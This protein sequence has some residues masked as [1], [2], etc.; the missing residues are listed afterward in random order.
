MQELSL[1]LLSLLLCV[2]QLISSKICCIKKKKIGHFCENFCSNPRVTPC[3]KHPHLCGYVHHTT[4]A[5]QIKV[6]LIKVNKLLV[7]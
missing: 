4:G 7:H 3:E 5:H 1:P 2:P 6:R